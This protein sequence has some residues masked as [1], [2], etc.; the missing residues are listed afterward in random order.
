MNLHLFFRKFSRKIKGGCFST[1]E[2]D[3]YGVT[4]G[5]NCHIFGTVDRT[6]GFLLSIG[7]DVTI[8]PGSVLLTHDGSTKMILGYSKVGR[9]D[10]G[11]NVFIGAS[12]IVLPG[13]K[14]GN[15]VI[16]GAGSVVTKDIPDGSVVVGNPARVIGIYN[17]YAEKSRKQLKES[18]VWNTHYLEKTD[19]EK[20][21]MSEVLQENRYGFDL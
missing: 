7:D 9:I 2:L 4:V 10:I 5:E 21:Q 6:H 20:K 8:A 11:S 12:C 14:I 1:E 17:D 19:K 13:V 3:S 16:V 15:N 18:P